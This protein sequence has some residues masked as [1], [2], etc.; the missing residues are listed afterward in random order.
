LIAASVLI[1]ALVAAPPQTTVILVRHAEK[2]AEPK[3]DPV[4]SDAGTARARALAVALHDAGVQAILTTVKQR[5]RMTAQ[6]LAD[7]LGVKPEIVDEN[8]A[9][10]IR[11]RHAGQVVLVVGH[12]NTVPEIVKALGA[13][14]PPAIC[15][16]EYDR[17]FVVSLDGATA[18]LVQARYGAATPPGPDCGAMMH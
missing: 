15:D 11:Q 8:V 2:A 7:A 5:T 9:E 14:A 17:L 18:R 3:N 4:L 6:P 12:S 1:A 10:A 13:R 16:E